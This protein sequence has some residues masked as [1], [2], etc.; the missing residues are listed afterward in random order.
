M[1]TGIKNSTISRGIFKRSKA[2]NPKVILCP[3]VKNVI[4]H[5]TFFHWLK[6]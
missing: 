1:V 3:M 2:A 4:S 5:I 6:L